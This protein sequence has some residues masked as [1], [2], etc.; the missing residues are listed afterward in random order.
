LYI[1]IFAGNFEFKTGTKVLSSSR[2][3]NS[4][5]I[6]LFNPSDSLEDKASLWLFGILSIKRTAACDSVSIVQ[7]KYNIPSSIPESIP[8]MG[9]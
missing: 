1:L 5:L 3:C 8:T 2:D 6:E 9:H 4:R 7:G